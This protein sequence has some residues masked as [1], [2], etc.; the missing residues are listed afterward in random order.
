MKDPNY[1]VFLFAL[2]LSVP[3]GWLFAAPTALVQPPP[4]DGSLPIDQHL[5]YLIVAGVAFGLYWAY[6]QI[7]SQRSRD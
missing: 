7:K 5:H 2:L 1:R 6:K 3:E 4:P